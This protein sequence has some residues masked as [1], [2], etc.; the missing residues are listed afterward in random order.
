[1]INFKGSGQKNCPASKVTRQYPFL[2][3]VEVRLREGKALGSEEGTG[4]EM[5]F[6]MSR[7]K[8]LSRRFTAYDRDFDMNIGR[9]S[10]DRNFYLIWGRTIRMQTDL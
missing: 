6:G 7:G 4:L 10:L 3:L 9:A 5:G 1:V 8:N 2:F